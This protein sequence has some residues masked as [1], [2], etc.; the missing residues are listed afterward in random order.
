MRWARADESALRMSLTRCC[1]RCRLGL[2]STTWS[3]TS[4]SLFPTWKSK[5]NTIWCRD[6][7]VSTSRPRAIST[8]T[9]VSVDVR[10]IARG[11][12]WTFSS[13]RSTEN[14][15]A[16]IS[17]RAKKYPRN[18]QTYIQFDK[19]QIKIQPGMVRKVQLTNLFPGNLALEEIANGFI[20]SNSDFLLNDVYPSLEN[21]L[22][23]HF[24]A[25]GNKIAGE[26]SFDELF[27]NI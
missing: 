24:T 21:S 2:I 6:C 7:L 13:F 1:C 8:L 20:S 15:K 18:G 19:F 9:S 5:E 4:S 22:A 3:S 10:V 26:A 27:P 16:R 14:S 17:L 11:S 12:Q 23:E 25:V